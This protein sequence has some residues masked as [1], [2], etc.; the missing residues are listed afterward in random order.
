MKLRYIYLLVFALTTF[1]ACE[2]STTS[3]SS[4]GTGT[5]GSTARFTIAKGYLYVVDGNELHAFSLQNPAA[6]QQVYSLP[7]S[8]INSVETIFP[9]KDKLFIGSTTGMFIVS[10]ADPAQP[11][12]E[13]MVEHIAACDPVVADDA[14][15]YVTVRS[16]GNCGHDI[17]ALYVYDVSTSIQSPSEVFE[18]NMNN[19]QGLA[20]YNN[21]LYVCDGSSGL[22]VFD[23]QNRASPKKL[24]V[25]EGYNF[26]DCIPVN[27]VLICMVE[28]GM[29]LYDISHPAEPQKLSEIIN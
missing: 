26:L 27:D 12:A 5:G 3:S 22:V 29:V 7:L 25:K 23:L 17:N 4:A 19:P 1:V 9:W 8:F 2:K 21:H 20:L 13:G 15:A 11:V 10:I 16:A 28:K 24:I 6:P 14:Y 18:G